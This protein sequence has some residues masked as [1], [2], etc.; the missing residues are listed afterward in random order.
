MTNERIGTIRRVLG[1]V[2]AA[3][4]VITGLC[5]MAACAGIYFTGDRI[6]TREIAGAALYDLRYLLWTCGGMILVGL[7]FALR[8]PEAAQKPKAAK[9]TALILKRM[10]EKTDLSNCEGE[11]LAG[12]NSQRALRRRDRILGGILIGVCCAVFLGY[13]LQSGSFHQSE[14]NTSMIRAMGVLLPCVLI[15]ALFGILAQR[16][17]K[18][19]ME[20]E[21]ELLKQVGTKKTAASPAPAKE[22]PPIATKVIFILAVVLLIW[23]Y[24]SGGTVDVLTKAINICT[25]CVGL[26]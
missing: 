7:C 14:I 15:P 22:R 17:E 21:I 24:L 18:A 20:T 19:S 5:L 13:A 11:L 4:I 25:E 23:G 8:F 2:T 3:A 1:I 26:G 10:R 12:I 6:F 9:Q 16:R